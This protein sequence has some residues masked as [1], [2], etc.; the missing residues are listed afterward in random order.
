MKTC[1][2]ALS[3]LLLALVVGV[4]AQTPPVAPLATP[5]P[6]P[7]QPLPYSHR[8]HLELGLLECGDCHVNP[9]AGSLMTF[10]DTDTCLS[11][12]ESMP[13]G[14]ATLKR[15]VASRSSGSPIP[16]VRVYRLADYVYWSHGT[17]I[18]AG[19]AC[20]TCHGPVSER[21]TMAVETNVT[22]KQGCVTC[23]ETRQVLTDCGGCHEP[24][25]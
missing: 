13:A 23:H 9:D 6:A 24:R 16:W 19:I 15:L 14:A 25:Q 17:H 11:C 20:E 10:P 21:D 8:Q 12:H 18:G 5:R 3:M 1:I 2:G 22:T 4:R 7:E